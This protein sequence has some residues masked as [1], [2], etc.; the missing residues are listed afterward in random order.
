MDLMKN[1]AGMIAGSLL[2]ALSID[3][4]AYTA[5]A[6]AK[7]HKVDAFPGNPTADQSATN[8]GDLDMW[9]HVPADMP[10][11][12]PVVVAMHGCTQNAKA[13][14]RQSGWSELAEK[15]KFYVI[16]PQ[17]KITSDKNS[18]KL[19]NPYACFNWAGYYGDRLDRGE[20]ENQSIIDMIAWLKENYSI[21]EKRIF[22]T[23]FSAGGAMTMTMIGTWPEVFAG[24]APMAGIPFRCASDVDSAFNCM[25]LNNDFFFSPRSGTGCESG[26]ACMHPNTKK[27]PEQWL[28]V[29]KQYGPQDYNGP[30]PRVIAW[31]ADSDQLVDDDN[32]F[33]ITKQWTAVHGISVDSGKHVQLK[34][35]N[36][37]HQAISFEKDGLPVLTT[38]LLVD[39][40]HGIAVDPGDGADQGGTHDDD[41]WTGGYAFDRDI[42]S[43]Y[44]TAKFW[45][46]AN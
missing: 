28:Q 36:T 7:L 33:E 43:V 29:L 3:A 9:L 32:L 40:T 4:L 30:Y 23:G 25:G 26:E 13:F 41:P 31:A 19:G 15:H 11:N 20:G 12:A 16:F 44:Y 39:Q 37:N 5:P 35:G 17:Q 27:T 46:I 2:I 45:G 6:A 34:A 8:P 10:E 22:I 14:D 38:V 1:I 42:H 18:K 24:A 21:D